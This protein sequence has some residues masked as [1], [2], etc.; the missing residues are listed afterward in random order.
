MKIKAKNAAVVL[1]FLLFP[2][3]L[4]ACK[5][6]SGDNGAIALTDVGSRPLMGDPF[7]TCGS[8]LG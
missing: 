8:Y 3:I 4:F 1:L 2:L 5:T 6:G 7:Q